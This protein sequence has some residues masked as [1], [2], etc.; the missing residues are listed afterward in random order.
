MPSANAVPFTRVLDNL[1]RLSPTAITKWC[2]IQHMTSLWH[3]YW[4]YL[5]CLMTNGP[6]LLLILH[7]SSTGI[8]YT[9]VICQIYGNYQ[10]IFSWLSKVIYKLEKVLKLS[11]NVEATLSSNYWMEIRHNQSVNHSR[12]ISS[13]ELFIPA[14][15]IFI[16]AEI[17]NL[18]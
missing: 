7:L 14:A 17:F 12:D 5:V 10:N 4:C 2:C 6:T 13:K 18:L 9:Q 11:R 3:Q 1:W 8:R 15:F 16:S